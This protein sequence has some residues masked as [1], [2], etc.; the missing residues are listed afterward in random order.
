VP[1]AWELIREQAPEGRERGAAAAIFERECLRSE[2]PAIVEIGYMELVRRKGHEY[3]R[4]DLEATI[5]A[6]LAVKYQ[7]IE[8]RLPGSLE[9]IRRPSVRP[10]PHGSCWMLRS[11]PRTGRPGIWLV[12]YQESTAIRCL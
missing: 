10:S 6:L 9:K 3:A 1:D 7:Q 5:L 8:G 2:N 11:L 4:L 12:P